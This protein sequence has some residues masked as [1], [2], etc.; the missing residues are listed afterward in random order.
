RRDVL[1]AVFAVLGG[2]DRQARTTAVQQVLDAVE[3][4]VVGVVGDISHG[5]PPRRRYEWNAWRVAGVDS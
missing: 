2:T 5:A 3:H 1:A 4:Q